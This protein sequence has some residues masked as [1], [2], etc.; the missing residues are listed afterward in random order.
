L[1]TIVEYATGADP[2]SR[3]VLPTARSIANRLA[4]TFPRNTT[5]TDIALTVQG[6]DDLSVWADLA[7]SA[8]GEPMIPLAAGVSLSENGI[9][10][11]RTVEFRD[12]YL[13]TDSAHPRRFLRLHAAPESAGA[14]RHALRPRHRRAPR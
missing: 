2:L 1:R 8:G 13:T 12:L 11:R 7:R 4:L 3:T 10:V 5:A 9:G 14:S 6:S